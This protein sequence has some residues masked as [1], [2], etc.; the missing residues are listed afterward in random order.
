MK[1]RASLTLP[2]FAAALLLVSAMP[3]MAA[4][5]GKGGLRQEPLPSSG[6]APERVPESTRAPTTVRVPAPPSPLSITHR[7]THYVVTAGQ[8]YEQRGR[9]LVAVSAP[10]GVM[11][12]DLPAGHSMRWIG[13]APYFYAD[14][15]YYVWRER[16][17]R[18]EILPQPPAQ[19]AAREHA[20]TQ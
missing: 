15:L 9:D 20:P 19:D 2:A 18:Y 5:Y 11:V 8:W 4:D 17:R 1:T 3:S 13:G 12:K 14:G 6:K 16:Q 10:A 7:G